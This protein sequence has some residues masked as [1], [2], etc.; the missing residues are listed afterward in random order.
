[1]KRWLATVVVIGISSAVVRADITIVQTTTIEGGM[2]AMAPGGANPSPKITTRIKGLKS[3]T[4]M[5]LP[6]TLSL[7]TI[8]DLVAK[9]L[10]VLK[11]DLKT[12][13]TVDA[14]AAAATTGAP[15]VTATVSL[16][17]TVAP[18]G[19]SQVIDGLKCDEYTLTTAVGIAEM[20]GAQ[21]PPEAAEQMKGLTMVMKGSMWVTRDAPGA[22][23]YVAYQKALTKSDLAAATMKASGVNLPGLDKMTKAMAGVDGLTYLMVMDM[24]VEGTGQMADMM[25]QMMGGMKITT[26]VTSISAVAIGEDQFK[27]PEGYTITK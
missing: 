19:K 8:T 27:I 20:L 25:R 21:L 11:H 6:P 2:A 1:M 13:Q 5:D 3:R 4:D 26:K 22:A 14:A 9:Q 10:I 17:A 18:T 16:D 7:S 12:A 24:T 23:E 15:A